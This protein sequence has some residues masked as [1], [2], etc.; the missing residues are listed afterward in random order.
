V[1]VGV[2]CAVSVRRIDVPAFFN[3]TVNCEKYVEVFFGQ[4]FRELTEEERFCRWFQQD[5]ATA[6]TAHVSVQAFS[7]VFGDRIISSGI[8]TGR[9][10]DLNPCDFFFWI[11]LTDKVYNGS[12]RTEE[13]EETNVISQQAY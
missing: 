13:L 10:L 6:H 5:S 1:K 8:W 11:C 9:S 4:F 3:E 12:P 7:D 2:W